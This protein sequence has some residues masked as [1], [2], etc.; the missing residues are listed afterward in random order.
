MFSHALQL[1]ENYDIRLKLEM[2][3]D[4]PRRVRV[5]RKPSCSRKRQANRRINVFT[6]VIGVIFLIAQ[7]E[8]VSKLLEHKM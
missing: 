3:T 7:I 5:L 4:R 2:A 1:E 6:S 8:S